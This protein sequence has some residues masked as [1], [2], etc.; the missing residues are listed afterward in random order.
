MT[1]Q[2]CTV[3][4]LSVQFAHEPLFQHLNFELPAAQCSALIGRNGQGKSILI[5]TPSALRENFPSLVEEL[6]DALLELPLEVLTDVVL[7]PFTVDVDTDVLLFSPS[8]SEISS[9]TSSSVLST[10]S[11]STAH[12]INDIDISEMLMPVRALFEIDFILYT[13]LYCYNNTVVMI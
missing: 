8:P 5:S 11:S 1:Q 6:L 4:N 10:V 9:S 3:K 2:A 12:A 13:S 7:F